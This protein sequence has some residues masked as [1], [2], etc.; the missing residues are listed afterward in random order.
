MHHYLVHHFFLLS[1]CL[2]STSKK[3]FKNGKTSLAGEWAL[4]CGEWT[5]LAD[6]AS[7][8]ANFKIV[9]LPHFV[10]T[11]RD[12]SVLSE[13]H[14]GTYMFRLNLS[15]TFNEPAIRM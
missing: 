6:I 4:S 11:L 9:Q 14:F 1:P 15:R 12:E 7:S 10:N 5:S 3:Q 2:P 13:Y 8:E